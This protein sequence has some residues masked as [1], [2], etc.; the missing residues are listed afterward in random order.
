MLLAL[1]IEPSEPEA[2][3]E[4]DKT[5]VDIDEDLKTEVA[6]PFI[7]SDRESLSPVLNHDRGFFALGLE[8]SA[9][10]IF[11]FNIFVCFGRNVTRGKQYSSELLRVRTLR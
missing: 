5:M 10:H 11:L 6:E 4:E 3:E 7:S 1:T 2:N 9:T 8:S